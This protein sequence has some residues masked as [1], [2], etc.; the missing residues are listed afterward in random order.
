MSAAVLTV[1]VAG[2]SAAAQDA[3]SEPTLLTGGASPELDQMEPVQTSGETVTAASAPDEAVAYLADTIYALGYDAG[4]AGQVLQPEKRAIDL[5]W[6]GELPSDVEELI[7]GDPY[8]VQ[9]NVDTT[10]EF[11]REEAM[12][13][14][15]AAVETSELDDLQITTA[16][17]KPD[18]TGIVVSLTDDAPA[19][20]SAAAR[21]IAAATDVEADA[22]TVKEDV[23]DIFVPTVDRR[24]NDSAPYKGGGRIYVDGRNACSTAFSALDG[25]AGRLL[26]AAHCV[27]AE[28]T[29]KT[30]QDGGGTRIAQGD[31]VKRRKSIDSM[32]IDPTTSPASKGRIFV[33][34]WNS[35]ST[36]EVVGWGS[37]HTG[38]K[39]CAGGATTGH[40]CGNI[41]DDAVTASGLNGA[42][43][44]VARATTGA[45]Q[46]GA[47]SG[48]P[49]YEVLD[50]GNIRAK[51][52]VY[53]GTLP[54]T[55]A[56]GT[57]NPD[58]DPTCHRDLVY[59]P[60]SVVLSTWGYTLD[61]G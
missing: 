21:E 6:K 24:S 41:I 30:V 59:V 35:D 34:G 51:G 58:V 16:S 39:V 13:A 4:Y 29:N 10:A 49:V 14:A 27:T 47:D 15:T 7:S 37:N 60:I 43:Y 33:S 38:Q 17:V 46:G 18:G 50:S 48:G 11:T 31:A 20:P 32:S 42:F 25:G 52:V 40:H 53:A 45:F 57:H 8:G 22:V 56:C 23:G 28:N 3:P 5:Y 55:T 2:A 44:V 36:R 1:A 54:S 26:S 12:A 19:G 9:V 61:L